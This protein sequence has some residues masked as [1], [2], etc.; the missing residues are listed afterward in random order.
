[1]FDTFSQ[2]L[3]ECFAARDPQIGANRFDL[4]KLRCTPDIHSQWDVKSIANGN[5]G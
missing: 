3:C 1:M 2:R 4:I 5:E